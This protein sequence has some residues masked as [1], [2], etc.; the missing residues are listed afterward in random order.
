MLCSVAL[1]VRP[2]TPADFDAVYALHAAAFGRALE[3]DLYDTLRRDGDTLPLSRVAV[4]DGILAG[5]VVCSRAWVGDV[6]VV[7]L[8][9]VGVLPERQ[10]EGIGSALVRAVVADAGGAPLLAL[11]GSP[12][13]YG[14]FGFAA[15]PRVTPPDPA[16][17]EHFQVLRH[18]ATVEGAFR[19]AR[20]FDLSG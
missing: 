19:Y 17:G 5:S 16:W 10:G 6:E 13:F 20:A 18:D 4:E 15:D 2:E 8:G 14:R 3:A 12:A 1:L 7:A 9:P 11:L